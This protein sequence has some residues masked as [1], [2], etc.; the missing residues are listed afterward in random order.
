MCERCIASALVAFVVAEVDQ[1]SEAEAF[2]LVLWSM[3]DEATTLRLPSFGAARDYAFQVNTVARKLLGSEVFAAR[4]QA[5][6]EK[7][8]ALAGASEV[9]ASPTLN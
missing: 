3:K 1:T 6:A 7:W 8:M 4:A 5:V 2:D 9:S